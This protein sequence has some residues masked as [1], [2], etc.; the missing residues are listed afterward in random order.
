MM[1]I[2]EKIVKSLS[3]TKTL[4]SHIT[5]LGKIKIATEDTTLVQG[6]EIVISELQSSH[7][8]SKS[9]TTPICLDK[10]NIPAIKNMLNYVNKAIGTKKP[11]WQILAERNGWKPSKT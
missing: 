3:E 4:A 11:E 1:N 2:Y 7:A 5:S 9:K 8:N 6:L 10:A